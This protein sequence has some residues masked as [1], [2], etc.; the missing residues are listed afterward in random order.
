MPAYRPFAC[1]HRLSASPR[2]V[3]GQLHSIGAMHFWHIRHIGSRTAPGGARVWVAACCVAVLGACASTPPQPTNAASPVQAATAREF[4]A[5]SATVAASLWAQ[6]NVLPLAVASGLWVHRSVGSRARSEYSTVEHAGRPALLASSQRGDSWMQLALQYSGPTMG[7][8]RFSW[9]VNALNTQADLADR[10]LDD[11]V[12]RVIL[13]FEDDRSRFSVRD[14][15]LS[16]LVQ[17]ATGEPLPYATLMY[18]WDHR[19]PAGTVIAHTRTDRIKLMVVESG[20]QRLGQWVDIERD[21]RAD[22]ETAFGKPP[23]QLKGI[24]LMTDSNNTLAPAQAWFGP[25]RWS[26]SDAYP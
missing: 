1:Y 22:Y 10:S 8:L 6:S 19:Y 3:G 17:L 18:V 25:L 26:A 23:K 12:A 2:T 24:A 4:G 9:F 21:V 11:A 5:G 14:N 16:E 7:R 20:T 15:L 13:Q